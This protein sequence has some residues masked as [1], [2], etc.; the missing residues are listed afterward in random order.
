MSRSRVR[1]RERPF[2]LISPDRY[3]ICDLCGQRIAPGDFIL[4]TPCEDD[5]ALAE[6][7]R[8]SVVSHDGGCPP[9]W[10]PVVLAGGRD[11]GTAQPSLPFLSA[12]PA[13]TSPRGANGGR[14]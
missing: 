8:C 7:G 11:A 2:R 10:D 4:M 14:Q 13:S 6:Q 3:V 12:V 9:V 5:D 1:G